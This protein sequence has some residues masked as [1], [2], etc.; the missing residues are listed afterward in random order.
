T[1]IADL[2]S[3]HSALP[4]SLYKPDSLKAQLGFGYEF[5]RWQ[6]ATV[7]YYAALRVT[8][9]T[10]QFVIFDWSVQTAPGNPDLVAPRAATL[11]NASVVRRPA[12]GTVSR[13]L[14]GTRGL[15]SK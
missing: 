14:V 15:R 12:G 2:D 9:F 6:S 13:G 3:I 8:A 1:A 11:T 10:H 4:D 5:V 7:Y